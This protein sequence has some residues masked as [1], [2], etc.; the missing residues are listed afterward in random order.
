MP[1]QPANPIRTIRIPDALRGLDA[2]VERVCRIVQ[3][4]TAKA[5]RQPVAKSA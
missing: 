2:L 4:R 3:C 1:S 5:P